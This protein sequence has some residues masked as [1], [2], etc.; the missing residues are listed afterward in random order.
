M[1]SYPGRDDCESQIS[2]QLDFRSKFDVLCKMNLM[3]ASCKS[4]VK[5]M[6]KGCFLTR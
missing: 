2:K 5:H 1:N 6:P 3:C 4:I